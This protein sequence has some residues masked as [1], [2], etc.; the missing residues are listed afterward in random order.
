MLAT[1]RTAEAVQDLADAGIETL[2]LEVTSDKSI[3]T[4]KDEVSERTGGRLDYLVNN[5]GRSKQG[6]RQ[7]DH[8]Y[9]YID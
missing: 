5:A 4:C 8:C 3:A 7:E 9:V 2:L 1:A 6:S